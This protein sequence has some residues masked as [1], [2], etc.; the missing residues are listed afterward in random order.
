ML[1]IRV[2]Q[3]CSTP[4]YLR[5]E[6]RARLTADLHTLGIPRLDAEQALADKRPNIPLD[7]LTSGRAERLLGLMEGWLR[8]VRA[9]A[10]EAET[11]DK[12]HNLADEKQPHG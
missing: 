2:N 11:A 12:A 8:D 6:T 1:E 3:M 10:L 9:H 5:Q 4:P 7:Q